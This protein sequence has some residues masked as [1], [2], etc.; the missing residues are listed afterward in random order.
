MIWWLLAAASAFAQQDQA[1]CL[2]CHS[3]HQKEFLTHKHASKGLTC[4]L[5][6][7]PSDQHRKASGAASPDKVAAPDEIPALCGG[8]H[9]APRRAY[10]QSEHGKL[11]L[12]G[13]K[14]RAPHCGTCHG[15][16]GPRSVEAMRRQCARCHLQL[17]TAC[18]AKSP[19]PAAKLS[20]TACH[21][22]HT[23][24]RGSG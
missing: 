4:T 8:C 22:P 18:Q 3:E 19:G 21:H 6:H 17:P 9:P 5:C 13:S 7:G 12:A 23:Q 24:V 14:I 10:E 11:V 2:P 15:V 20:C 1:L 16:H